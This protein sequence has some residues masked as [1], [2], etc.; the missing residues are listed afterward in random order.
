MAFAVT[1]KSLTAMRERLKAR[2]VKQAE[3]SALTADV[4]KLHDT[5]G[6]LEAKRDDHAR[7]TPSAHEEQSCARRVLEHRV[8]IAAAETRLAA[9]AAEIARTTPPRVSMVRVLADLRQ[10]AEASVLLRVGKVVIRLL[11]GM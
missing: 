5:I 4:A 2:A 9:L 10:R 3:L 8:K 1:L 11:R 6:K 7:R